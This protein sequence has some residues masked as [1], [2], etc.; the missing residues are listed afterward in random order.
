[1]MNHLN[2]FPS[3]ILSNAFSMLY[4][5]AE[6]SAPAHHYYTADEALAMLFV[7]VELASIASLK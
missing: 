5:L 7:G 6:Q 1:M 3:A 2:S 4:F